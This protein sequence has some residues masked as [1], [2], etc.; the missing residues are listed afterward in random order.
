MESFTGSIILCIIM[1]YI[2]LIIFSFFCLFTLTAQD[3][4]SLHFLPDNITTS[5]TNPAML[6]K[7]NI[8]IG[9]PNAGFNLYH[10]SGNFNDIF[11]ENENE[12]LDL[13]FG[14]WIS[15]LSATNQLNVNLEAETFRFFIR[16]GKVGINVNHELRFQSFFEYPD[17]Y[18][19]LLGEGNAQ[20]IGQTVDIGP[21]IQQNAFHAIGVGISY[22]WNEKLT[23]ALRPKLLLGIGNASTIQKSATVTTADEF[24]Q[25][26]VSTDYEL[27]STGILN[28]NN[29]GFNFDFESLDKGFSGNTGFALDFGVQIKPIEK[30]DIN[31]SIV[32]AFAKINWKKNARNYDSNTTNTFSG[33]DIDFRKI[34]QGDSL[35]L[36]NTTDT[37]NFDNLFEF[38]SRETSYS[39]ELPSRVYFSAAFQLTDR[40]ALHGLFYNEAFRDRNRQAYSLGVQAQLHKIFNLGLNYAYRFG[41]A[42]N[43]GLNT[44]FRFGPVQLFAAT[45]NIIHAFQPLEAD[46]VNGRIGLNLIF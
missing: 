30:L 41:D 2:T 39:T 5:R 35:N 17:T 1:K 40:F 33:V 7:D 4:L 9:L 19:K 10:S 18:V 8:V 36:S 37:I 16:R 26:T 23:V 42:T 28:Y 13:D 34:L 11:V 20:Y 43:I 24:Y 25:T 27:N 3:E 12:G 45:D 31:I 44:S 29:E 22:D 15:Q 14:N 32:D 21:D 46:N 38:T 6:P